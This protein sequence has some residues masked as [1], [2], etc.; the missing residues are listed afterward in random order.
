MR[1][2]IYPVMKSRILTLLMFFSVAFSAFAYDFE[3][4]DFQYNII[5]LSDRTAEIVGTTN[6]ECEQVNIPSEVIFNGIG[7]HVISIGQK[8][9]SENKNLKVVVVGDG[10]RKIDNSFYDCKS[11]NK[12]EL[13]TYT[14]SLINA[15]E[16][17]YCLRE[18]TFK[19]ASC[20]VSGWTFNGCESLS[21]INIPSISTWCSYRFEDSLFDDLKEDV[22]LY[23]QGQPIISVALPNGLTHIGNYQFAGLRTIKEMKLPQT[24]R[25]IGEGAF[26]G[27]SVKD[28]SIPEECD[29]I[30]DQAFEGL[31]L[32]KLIIPTNV[33]YLGQL[34]GGHYA[35]YGA[36]I[37][38]LIFEETTDSITI[39]HTHVTGDNSYSQPSNFMDGMSIN[40]I[41]L[42][43]PI[44][45]LFYT[46]YYK[47]NPNNSAMKKPYS[48]PYSSAFYRNETLN[49]IV[50]GRY[51]RELSAKTFSGCSNIDSLIKESRIPS[52]IQKSIIASVLRP[53]VP[54][55]PVLSVDQP[56]N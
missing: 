24:V 34:G 25:V 12:V 23:V 20:Y 26:A 2:T 44:K 50:I 30:L 27:I 15:F 3:V 8:V 47:S 52:P 35:Y 41:Q 56:Q 43:R 36:T 48:D 5:N 39:N 14:D 22:F 13:G 42:R 54:N 49:K 37:G 11:L 19:S 21:I 40:E 6:N 45:G 46:Y 33:K 17:C 1:T 7:I 51:F 18:I 4:G 31:H 16:Y 53:N 29:S 10:I 9:F 32:E 28:I 38:K 55:T